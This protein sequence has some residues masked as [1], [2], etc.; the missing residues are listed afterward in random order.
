MAKLESVS[1]CHMCEGVCLHVLVCMSMRVFKCLCVFVH[2]GVYV[3]I[4]T[5]MCL[6]VH[7]KWARSRRRETSGWMFY[8]P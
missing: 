5:C 4:C 3:C 6:C 2:V 7:M 8:F 1:V